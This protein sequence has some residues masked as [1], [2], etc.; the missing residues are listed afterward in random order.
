LAQCCQPRRLRHRVC[1]SDFVARK[2]LSRGRIIQYCLAPTRNPL[3]RRTEKT[4]ELNRPYPLPP[5]WRITK[6][7]FLVT[8]PSGGPY[9]WIGPSRYHG[10]AQHRPTRAILPAT[11]HRRNSTGSLIQREKV[12]A[13][14]GVP[15][16]FFMRR[17]VERLSDATKRQDGEIVRLGGRRLRELGS[18]ATPGVV[19][20]TF[21]S[22]DQGAF[23][24]TLNNLVHEQVVE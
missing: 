9:F 2:P 15:R 12:V 8:I 11:P 16:P 13:A 23:S 5:K 1:T 3:E 4:D 18:H 19:G 21:D 14:P 7:N 24:H 20:Q 6:P 17:K 10:G 22:F